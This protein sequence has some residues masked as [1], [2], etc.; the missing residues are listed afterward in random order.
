MDWV[1]LAVFIV[2]V[3]AFCWWMSGF[4]IRNRDAYRQY[5]EAIKLDKD[6]WDVYRE[7]LDVSKDSNRLRSEELAI[8]RELVIELRAMRQAPPASRAP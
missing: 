6:H 5:F 8:L 4:S 2:C 1:Q 7:G 3:V